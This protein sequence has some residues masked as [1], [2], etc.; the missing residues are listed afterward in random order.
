MITTKARIGEL[1]HLLLIYFKV[2]WP[3]SFAVIILY[4]LEIHLIS[5][6]FHR[7][8]MPGFILAYVL[9]K[10][11]GHLL[12]KKVMV[13]F[14]DDCIEIDEID[15][16]LPLSEIEGVEFTVSG[17]KG[18]VAYRGAKPAKINGYGNFLDLKLANGELL[19]LNVF[20][21]DPNTEV[22]LTKYLSG[23]PNCSV[24][25]LR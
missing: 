3:I 10:K 5:E 24:Q 17:Y 20:I 22:T 2:F 13:A 4:G 21:E 14:Y 15:M 6:T 19:S 16:N 11:F 9:L 12:L 23:L 1:P 25:R 7:I 18:E 8:F